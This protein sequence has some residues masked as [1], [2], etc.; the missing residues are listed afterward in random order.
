MLTPPAEA[1]RASADL[2]DVDVL[3]ADL[4]KLCKRQQNTAA[5]CGK[6]TSFLDDSIRCE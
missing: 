5:R 4:D 2:L 1:P 3:A 6:A